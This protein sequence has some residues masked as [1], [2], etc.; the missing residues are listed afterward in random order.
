MILK[1]L[2]CWWRG[3]GWRPAGWPRDK[4]GRICGLT[5]WCPRCDATKIESPE[6]LANHRRRCGTRR[7]G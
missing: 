6:A 7:P 5:L 4:D 3:H 1:L 2:A